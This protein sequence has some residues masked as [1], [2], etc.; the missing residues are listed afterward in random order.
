MATISFNNHYP[1]EVDHFWPSNLP[2]KPDVCFEAVFKWLKKCD[3]SRDEVHTVVMPGVREG[4]VVCAY[5]AL[6]G[7]FPIVLYS[8]ME[9]GKWVW[10]CFE[11]QTARQQKR[12]NRG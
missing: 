8:R 10:D 5:H 3:L 9:R 4:I 1:H 12:G 2:I 7:H 6:M 11:M